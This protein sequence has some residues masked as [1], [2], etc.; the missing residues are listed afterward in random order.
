MPRT[1]AKHAA[2][3]TPRSHGGDYGGVA[4]RWTEDI[5]VRAGLGKA[6]SGRQ[7]YREAFIADSAMTYTRTPDAVTVSSRWPLAYERGH[8]VGTVRGSQAFLY[9]ASIPPVGETRRPMVHSFRVVRR[10][11]MHWP[12]V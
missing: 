6:L 2:L 12:S 10:D 7:A 11:H 3:R 8:W 4:Q 1:F 9:P 5:T